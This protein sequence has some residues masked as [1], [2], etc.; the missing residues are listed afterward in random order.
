MLSKPIAEPPLNEEKKRQTQ[1][2]N[3]CLNKLND[4][5]PNNLA[6]NQVFMYYVME[7]GDAERN[8]D[9]MDQ[10][11]KEQFLSNN[12]TNLWN[13]FNDNRTEFNRL[14]YL[15]VE[16][17]LTDINATNFKHAMEKLKIH[18]NSTLEGKFTPDMFF[19][20]E[21]LEKLV[22]SELKGKTA[23][24]VEKVQEMLEKFSMHVI[25]YPY[26]K[27]CIDHEICSESPEIIETFMLDKF[28]AYN[29]TINL[30]LDEDR[31]NKN[32]NIKDEI[33]ESI[34]DVIQDLLTV[35]NSN[36]DEIKCFIDYAKRKKSID[37]VYSPELLFDEV[38][39][40]KIINPLMEDYSEK[41][42]YVE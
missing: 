30:K 8:F 10:Q 14:V 36:V 21:K 13:Y 28:K 37:K 35:K 4:W 27:Y 32:Q 2:Y 12:N 6:I 20:D 17:I 1:K 22:N 29:E 33:D 40:S 15:K 34:Y 19:V 5:F 25:K 31:F 24:C 39:L 41:F 23:I 7:F 16:K 9:Q 3:K 42:K 18:K 38:E 11:S 26:I